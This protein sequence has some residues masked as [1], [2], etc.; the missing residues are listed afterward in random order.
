MHKVVELDHGPDSKG[1]LQGL[2]KWYMLQR[3]KQR[4][5]MQCIAKYCIAFHWALAASDC[6]CLYVYYLHY[7][8]SVHM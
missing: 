1:K 5:V 6:S 4:I 8:A 3:S 7:A 2:R